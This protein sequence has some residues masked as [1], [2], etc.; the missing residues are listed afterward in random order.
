A[1]ARSIRCPVGEG[2]KRRLTATVKPAK[3]RIAAVHASVLAAQYRVATLAQVDYFAA[4]GAACRL[5]SGRI[6]QLFEVVLIGAIIY[7]H[8]RRNSIAALRAVLPSTLVPLC[9]M[10]AAESKP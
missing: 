5:K 10:M 1:R 6:R 8:F 2:P 4:F 9:V 3:L 7:E